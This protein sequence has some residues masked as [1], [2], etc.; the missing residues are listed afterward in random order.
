MINQNEDRNMTVQESWNAPHPEV[1]IN[2]LRLRNSG[3][4]D[5]DWKDGVFVPRKC[6]NRQCKACGGV[7]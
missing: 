3:G 4:H 7:K 1:I 6:G 5:W 2:V